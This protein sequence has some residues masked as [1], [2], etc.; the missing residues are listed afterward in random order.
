VEVRY[1]KEYRMNRLPLSKEEIDA[2]NNGGED[3]RDWRKIKL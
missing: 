3:V 2:I 1:D